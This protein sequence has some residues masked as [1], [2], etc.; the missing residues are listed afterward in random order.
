MRIQEAF[1][2]RAEGSGWVVVYAV[3]RNGLDVG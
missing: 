3:L 1:P 2:C